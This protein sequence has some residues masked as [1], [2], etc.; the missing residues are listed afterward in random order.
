MDNIEIAKIFNEIADV[1][2]LKNANPFRANAYRQAA[3]SIESLP[4]DIKDIYQDDKLKEIP[5]IGEKIA[6]HIKDLITKGHSVELDRIINSL[7]RGLVELLRINGLGPKKV[8]FIYKKFKVKSISD[9]KKLLNSHKLESQR[10]WG[11]KT[12]N[13]IKEGLGLYEKFSQRLPLGQVDDLVQK[14]LHELKKNYIIDRAEIAGSFRR[15]KETVGDLDFLATSKRP[16]QAINF[17]CQLPEVKNILSSGPTKANVFLKRGLEA[18]LRVVEPDSFGAALYYFTGSKAHNIATRKIGISKGLKINEYGIYKRGGRKI[19][20]REEMD[21]FKAIDLPWIPPEIRENTGEIEAARKSALPKL[22]TQKDIKGDLHVHSIWSEGAQTILEMA[23]AAKKFGYKYIAITDHDA[24]IGITHGLTADRVIKQLKEI[25][26][27]NKSLKDFKILSG[28]EIDIHKDGSLSLPDKV[29]S[30]LDVVVASVHSYFKQPR[31]EMT[32]R[33]VNAVRNVNVDI[34]AHPTTRLINRREPINVDLEEIYREAKK[35]KTI[36]EINSQW[37]RLDLNDVNA[38]TAKSF[39]VKF[40]ISTDSHYI[41]ELQ[42]IKFG[43]AIARRGWIEK[44]DV[45]NSMSLNNLLK[46]LK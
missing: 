7:P 5:G 4:Q 1:L 19:G 13:N 44:K 9:L 30:M 10:G 2:E 31:A 22:I 16:Q 21:V 32:K 18:D 8:K 46:S 37:N 28:I 33:I 38:R 12:V 35:N 23:Q 43:V 24:T 42:N 6:Q 39:G 41:S 15:S 26:K 3:L 45:V 34:I 25:K 20:G 36:L 11:E 40:A 29:L 14:I 27:A 17:F